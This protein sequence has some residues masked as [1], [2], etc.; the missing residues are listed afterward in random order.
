MGYAPSVLDDTC[1]HVFLFEH[2][3]SPTT[4]RVYKG[5]RCQLS[6]DVKR[7][8]ACLGLCSFLLPGT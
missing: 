6:R 1:L 2:S 8:K 4:G 7:L 3:L 5:M